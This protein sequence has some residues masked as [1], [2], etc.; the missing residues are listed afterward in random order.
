MKEFWKSSAKKLPKGLRVESNVQIV[1]KIEHLEV[2]KDVLFQSN[3]VINLGGHNWNNHKGRLV[4]GDESCISYN[5]VIIAA[6]IKGIEIGRNFD[7]GP[8]CGIFSSMTDYNKKGHHIFSPVVIGDDVILYH[9]V[10]VSPGVT[11]G[12]GAVVA[13]GSVVI[14]DVEA[15]TMVGGS[16]AV[17]IKKLN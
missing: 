11:I 14:N 4:I 5:T 6:G 7:C 17:L 2:G 9:G 13:A 10:T 12:D 3:V 1:G 16:P 8:N 15:Y